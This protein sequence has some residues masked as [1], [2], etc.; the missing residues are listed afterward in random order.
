MSPSLCSQVGQ[1]RE[2]VEKGTKQ[3]GLSR[4]TVGE[5]LVPHIEPSFFRLTDIRITQGGAHTVGLRRPMRA[6]K[7]Q[8]AT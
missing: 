1:S 7:M 4:I 2:H 5:G 6:D 3:G 8:S